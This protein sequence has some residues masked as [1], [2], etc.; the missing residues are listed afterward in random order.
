MRKFLTATNVVG[1]LGLAVVIA[2]IFFRP[3]LEKELFWAGCGLIIL[4]GIATLVT[5]GRQ[6]KKMVIR[7]K[8]ERAQRIKA[9]EESLARGY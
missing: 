7:S 5:L 1:H 2:A 9:R 3:V 4:S 6:H 8:E